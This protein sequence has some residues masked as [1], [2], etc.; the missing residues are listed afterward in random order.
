MFYPKT[1]HSKPERTSGIRYVL[2]NGQRYVG[3][4]ITLFNGRVFTGKNLTPQSQELFEIGDIFQDD[5]NLGL[6]NLRTQD[7]DPPSERDYE[8]GKIKRYFLKDT[9][10]GKIIETDNLRFRQ[11]KD[12]PILQRASIDWK[13]V[14]PEK[15]YT[16]NSYRV[17]GVFEENEIAVKNCN[18]N[19]LEKY[20]NG[21]YLKYN[22][23]IE[24][25]NADNMS[26]MPNPT[27][28]NIPSP[29]KKLN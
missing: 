13:I 11:E 25:K 21:D 2:A 26:I 28:F 8:N 18:M 17:M 20:I 22:R 3:F 27:H 14:G 7:I 4:F 23:N 29:G 5:N 12:T 10:S 9:R 19:G 15:S 6:D 1:K 24:P 16:V